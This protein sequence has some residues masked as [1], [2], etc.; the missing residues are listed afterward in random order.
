[1]RTVKMTGRGCCTS[2]VPKTITA[3]PHTTPHKTCP[4][5]R[6]LP[7]FCSTR[8]KP[9]AP[10]LTPSPYTL[11][12]LMLIYP[13]FYR[14]VFQAIALGPSAWLSHQNSARHH[15]GKRTSPPNP[16]SKM[17]RRNQDPYDRRLANL[18]Q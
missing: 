16:L 1:M 9:P 14:P 13:K 18:M 2:L 6:L 10:A 8:K 12:G 15:D 7:F 5:Y 17:A 4:S 11:A 3:F